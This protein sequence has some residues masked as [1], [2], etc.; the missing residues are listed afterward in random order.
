M[1]LP[2]VQEIEALHRKYAPSQEAFDLV[3]QHCRIVWDIAKQLIDSNKIDVNAELV[4]AG[5]LLHDI[6]LYR[7]IDV[8]GAINPMHIKH[9]IL[10]YELLKKEGYPETI[11][12]FASHHTGVGLSRADVLAQKLPLPPDDYT[13]ETNEELLVMYA[14]KFHS[15][16]QPPCF[17]TYDWYRDYVA[18][19]GDDKVLRFDRIAERFGVPMLS[20]IVAKYGHRVKG[21]LS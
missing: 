20:P 6:G 3:Y 21:S 8:A 11:C 10:G 12:R 14:D 13:A 15:K 2:T 17:V 16:N 4:K 7:L 1:Q 5:S 18:T 19:F 9:G